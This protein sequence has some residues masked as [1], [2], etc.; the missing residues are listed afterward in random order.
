MIPEIVQILN[1]LIKTEN[2][3][4]ETWKNHL[5]NNLTKWF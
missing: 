1:I 3:N 4:G 5:Y 2:G